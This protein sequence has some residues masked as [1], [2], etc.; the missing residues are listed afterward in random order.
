MAARPQYRWVGYFPTPVFSKIIQLFEHPVI[1]QHDVEIIALSCA[2]TSR[3]H[4]AR[5]TR[6]L[7][8]LKLEDVA[9]RN[10]SLDYDY[11]R[12]GK[13]NVS[14]LKDTIA[15]NNIQEMVI[16]SFAAKLKKDW[17]IGEDETDE[18]LKKY[19]STWERN[20]YLAAVF[21]AV[22]VGEN[23]ERRAEVEKHLT[24]EELGRLRFKRTSLEL[25][26]LQDTRVFLSGGQVVVGDV[27][28]DELLI[29]RIMTAIDYETSLARYAQYRMSAENRWTLVRTGSIKELRR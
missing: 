29:A 22:F 23:G 2:R 16:N 14:E 17:I 25:E 28:T 27:N 21:R 7:P 5:P 24:E 18:E 1:R 13:L 20:P 15:Q 10:V 19:R 11:R 3:E 6:P 12:H 9:I 26:R 8:F 4:R